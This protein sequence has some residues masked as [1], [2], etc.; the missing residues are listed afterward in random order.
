M[1]KT[2]KPKYPTI[3]VTVNTREPEGN[4][5]QYTAKVYNAIKDKFG[6]VAAEEFAT[7]WRALMNGPP[8]PKGEEAARELCKK[9]VA[10]KF[11]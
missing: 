9:W 6:A 10:I 11:N 3:R 5:F 4:T 1:A 2:V 7:E 8:D